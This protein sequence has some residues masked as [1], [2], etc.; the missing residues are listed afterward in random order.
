MLAI[1]CAPTPLMLIY[2]GFTTWGISTLQEKL[3]AMWNNDSCCIKL[4]F[5]N[6][7]AGFSVID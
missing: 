1:G 2:I 4:L 5:A 3:P 6:P 7:T